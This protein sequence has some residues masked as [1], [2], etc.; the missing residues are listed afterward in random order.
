MGKSKQIEYMCEPYECRDIKQK[1]RA[2][3]CALMYDSNV[4]YNDCLLLQ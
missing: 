3:D 2:A 4:G 1:R